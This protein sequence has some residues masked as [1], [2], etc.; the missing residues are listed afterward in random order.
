MGNVYEDLKVYVQQNGRKDNIKM[1]TS[2]TSVNNELVKYNRPGEIVFEATN[3]FRKLDTRSLKIQSANSF[4]T[5]FTKDGFEVSLIPESFRSRYLY[6][7]DIQGQFSVIN[8]DD[9]H[10]N[11]NIESDYV[12]VNFNFSAIEPFDSGGVYLIGS[13]TNWRPTSSSRLIYNQAN[14]MYETT[15]YIKQGYYE[16]HYVYFGVSQKAGTT[17]HTEN[18]FSDTRNNY[19]IYV[20]YKGN[21]DYHQ[22]LLGIKTIVNN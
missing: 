4:N 22:R 20:Y 14:K 13:F 5:V 8:R 12:K 10:L 19:T 1:L 3:E 15:L 11:H 21:G 18:N 7:A 9:T 16:Y 6:Y 17:M 2:P